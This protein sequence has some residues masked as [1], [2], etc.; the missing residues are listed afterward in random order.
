MT[1]AVTRKAF[2]DIAS[3]YD[4]FIRRLIPFYQEQNE[5]LLE[6]L[7]FQKEEH[8]S[9]LDLGAG[10]GILSEVIAKRFPR[11]EFTLLDMT[12]EMLE[13]AKI[14]LAPYP[15]QRNFIQGDFLGAAFGGPYDAIVAGLSLH[16]VGDEEKRQVF[17][18]VH[19]CLKPGGWFILRDYLKGETAEQDAFFNRVW[20]QRFALL[21]E[22][23]ERWFHD[24][25]Q[26]DKPSTLSSHLAWFRENGFIEAETYFRYFGFCVLAGRKPAS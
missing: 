3:H 5:A 17:Q 24:H 11:A 12:A 19:G 13:K 2:G 23:E 21:D 8:F 26:H 14:R 7:P 1:L 22:E 4:D 20:S 9:V 10:T 18:K 15:N 25:M 16:H 6:L